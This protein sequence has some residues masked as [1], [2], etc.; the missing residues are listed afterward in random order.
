MKRGCLDL[1][2]VSLLDIFPAY[3]LVR[4]IATEWSKTCH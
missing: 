1:T 3:V 4:K 2:D